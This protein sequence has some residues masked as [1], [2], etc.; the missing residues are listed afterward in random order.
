MRWEGRWVPKT[1]PSAPYGKMYFKP[2][3]DV[4]DQQEFPEMAGYVKCV[5]MIKCIYE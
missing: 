1:E 4:L 3:L 2:T 5:L